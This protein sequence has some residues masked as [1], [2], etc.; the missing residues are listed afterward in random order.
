MVTVGI[1]KVLGNGRVGTGIDLTLKVFQVPLHG[2][3][4]G[5]HFRIGRHFDMKMVPGF[6]ANELDQLI[7]VAQIATLVPHAGG[8]IAAQGNNTV[9]PLLAIE[10]QQRS[11][12]L[13]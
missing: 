4:L 3:C 7:G 9:D 10:M 13:P 11:D 6:T 8:Q 12:L 1:K 5:M 2:R